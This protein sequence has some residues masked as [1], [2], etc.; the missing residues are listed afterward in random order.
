MKNS[1]R[2]HGHVLNSHQEN[3]KKKHNDAISHLLDWKRLKSQIIVSVHWDA[4]RR[5]RLP[6]SGVT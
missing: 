1:S 6:T 5:E 4:A 2:I 3:E